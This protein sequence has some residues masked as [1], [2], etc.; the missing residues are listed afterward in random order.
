MAAT[1]RICFTAEKTLGRLAKWLRLLGFDTLYASGIEQS[2]TDTAKCR[3]A[4]TD[5]ILLTR[6]RKVWAAGLETPIIFIRADDP[7]EQVR[8]VVKTLN[9]TQSDIAPFS[10]CL[11]C[12]RQVRSLNRSHARG[13]VPD[14]IW[15]THE[16]FSICDGCRKI[17]WPGSHTRRA[18]AIINKLFH[19]DSP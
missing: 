4:G 1:D 15:T 17:F 8:Q 16:L 19:D 5:R 7:L 14:Y 13:R 9:L 10:R 18:A 6:T 12:N 11:R 2:V 3:D